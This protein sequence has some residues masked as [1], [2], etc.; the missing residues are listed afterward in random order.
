MNIKT[1]EHQMMS[2]I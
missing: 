2:I 1:N